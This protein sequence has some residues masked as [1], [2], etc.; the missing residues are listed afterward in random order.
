MYQALSTHTQKTA[1]WHR[2]SAK[3]TVYRLSKQCTGSVELKTSTCG[4]KSKIEEYH[5][6]KGAI[7]TEKFKSYIENILCPTLKSGDIVVKDNLSVHRN[8]DV[9]QIITCYCR[10]YVCPADCFCQFT[11]CNCC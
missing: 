8:K 10:Q 9:E 4:R 7:N 1:K 2:H 11:A 5:S 6:K 3:W